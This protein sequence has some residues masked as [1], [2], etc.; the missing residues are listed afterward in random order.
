MTYDPHALT[1]HVDGSAY[2]NPGGSGGI[3]GVVDYPESSRRESEVI[4]EMGYEDT[5]NS[6]MELR[7]CIQA[8]KWARNYTASALPPRILILTDSSYVSQH[9]K[10]APRWKKMKWRNKNGRPVENSD[11]W[12]ELLRIKSKLTVRTD[13]EWERGKSNQATKQVDKLAKRAARH[14][15]PTMDNGHSIGKVSRTRLPH[16]AAMLYPASGQIELIRV[17]RKEF[18]YRFKQKECKVYFEVFSPEGGTV[19]SKR[20]AYATP[21]IENQLHRHHFYRVQFNESIG[22]PRINV[23]L[24]EIGINKLRG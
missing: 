10:N 16:V 15:P 1:I 19:L 9:Q 8:L 24:E 17:Y 6:R 4:F 7:A 22:Y 18:L 13:I 11:L 21:E 20:I 3:A 23:I 2:N 5:T 14:V 12:K